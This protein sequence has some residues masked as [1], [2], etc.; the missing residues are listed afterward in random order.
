MQVI[1]F[2]FYYNSSNVES[3]F[4]YT[5]LFSFRAI[6]GF[7]NQNFIQNLNLLKYYSIRIEIHS[8]LLA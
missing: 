3:R 2:L 8:N 7:I 6:K 4:F 5:T 1:S